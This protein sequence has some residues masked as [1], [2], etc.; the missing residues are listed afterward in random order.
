[1]YVRKQSWPNLMHL[2]AIWFALEQSFSN[3]GSRHF[4]RWSSAVLKRFYKKKPQKN[5]NRHLTNEKMH[6]HMSVLKLLWLVA[7]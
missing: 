3:R 4:A 2:S 6:A 7:L 5:F 1:M